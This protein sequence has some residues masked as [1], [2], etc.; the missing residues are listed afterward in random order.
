MFDPLERFKDILRKADNVQPNDAASAIYSVVSDIS[1]PENLGRCKVALENFRSL[2]GKIS[3]SSNWSYLVGL[4]IGSGR[5]PKSLLGKSCLALPIHN[6]YEN[7]V[8]QITGALLYED[9]ETFPIPNQNNL[10]LEIISFGTSESFKQIV[11]LRNGKYIWEKICPLKHL[12][13]FGDT[14]E[15]D[16]DVGGDLQFP[17]EHTATDDTIVITSA[18]RYV[19]DSEQ[20]P[21]SF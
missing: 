14:L 3:Y 9:S 10:G 12:H 18:T 19:K 7:I 1:D 16:R 5:L 21:T 17:I 4:S 6:S 11:Q 8:V 13:K 15:Q 20:F 2:S